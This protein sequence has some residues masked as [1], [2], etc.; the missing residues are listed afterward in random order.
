MK[1]A[2][3][4]IVAAQSI[5]NFLSLDNLFQRG[6]D[7]GL[8]VARLAPEQV[9]EIEP[10]VRCLAGVKVSSTGIVNYREVYQ[11]YVNRLNYGVERCKPAHTLTACAR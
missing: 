11:K 2:G 9:Q 4:V 5:R 7:H 10:H 6:L 8:A 3:K 1:S